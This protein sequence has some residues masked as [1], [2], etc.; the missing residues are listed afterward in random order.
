MRTVRSLTL[1]ASLLAGVL[2]ALHAQNASSP[3][4]PTT[5]EGANPRQDG[6][7]RAGTPRP[8]SAAASAGA[9]P[10]SEHDAKHPPGYRKG[11]STPRD[12]DAGSILG[13]PK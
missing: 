6:S 12:S 2:P 10:R 1:A 7:T 3:P 11:S 5:G 8:P 13:T 4:R 9:P